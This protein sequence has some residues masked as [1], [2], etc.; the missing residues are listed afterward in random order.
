MHPEY[1]LIITGGGAAGLAG[2]QYGAR[3]NLKT[4]LVE[5]L[6]AGGQALL[7]DALENYPG[8]MGPVSGYEL[9]ETMRKQA[10]AFGAA[11]LTASATSLRREGEAFRV[12][13]SEGAL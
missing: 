12:E 10:E 3:A 1:D 11:F 9:S 4:L 6:A 5:E 13:T 7:I 8:V 2:A